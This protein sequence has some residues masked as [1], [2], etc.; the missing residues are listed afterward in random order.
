[1]CVY[2]YIYIHIY[3]YNL[4]IIIVIVAVLGIEPRLFPVLS[5]LPTT[6]PNT[7][8]HKCNIFKYFLTMNVGPTGNEANHHCAVYAQLNAWHTLKISC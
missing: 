5:K 1:M 3:I 2:I 8:P 7:Q 4:I 6:G